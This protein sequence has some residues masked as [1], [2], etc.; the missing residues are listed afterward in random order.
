[1]F[2]VPAA[3]GCWSLAS[4]C[5][6]DTARPERPVVIGPRLIVGTLNLIADNENP[7]QFMPPESDQSPQWQRAFAD[8]SAAWEAVTVAD[9]LELLDAA[10]AGAAAGSDDADVER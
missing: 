3:M 9:A 4:L 10:V 6:S 5:G 7:W 2:D 8:A 1:M